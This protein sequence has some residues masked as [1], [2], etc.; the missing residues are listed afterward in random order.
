[1]NRQ[2]LVEVLLKTGKNPKKVDQLVGQYLDLLV[3]EGED[4]TDIE[5]P[6]IEP[7]HVLTIVEC[8]VFIH[9][10]LKE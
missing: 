4:I 6:D 5:I 7:E 3:E 8:H 9:N 2:E 10:L 1:M